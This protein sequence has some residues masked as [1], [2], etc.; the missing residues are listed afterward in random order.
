MTYYIRSLWQRLL[1]KY[2][3]VFLC[4]QSTIMW[5]SRIRVIIIRKYGFTLLRE[6]KMSLTS[7]IY[8]PGSS[9]LLQKQNSNI[10]IEIV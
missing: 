9:S 3:Q 2:N 10:T 1:V 4:G 8:E 6:L 5:F 7:T